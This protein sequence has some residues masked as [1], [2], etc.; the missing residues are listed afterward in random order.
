MSFLAAVNER[1]NFGFTRLHGAAELGDV[2]EIE[3]LIARGANLELP[4]YSCE[5]KTALHLAVG[6]GHL[7]ATQLLVE[8]GAN[9][10]AKDEFGFA[11]NLCCFGSFT[12]VLLNLQPNSVAHCL[13]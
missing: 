1:D 11:R 10:N 8:R 6:G 4:V 2:S 13:R 3:R 7:D 5:K 9:I 12:D